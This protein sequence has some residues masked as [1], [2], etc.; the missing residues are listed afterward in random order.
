MVNTTTP[1]PHP[2]GWGRGEVGRLEHWF[3]VGGKKF[4]SESVGVAMQNR[5]FYS[6]VNYGLSCMFQVLR[7][8]GQLTSKVSPYDAFITYIHCM[9]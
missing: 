9:F 5:R 8:L 2:K 1:P 7:S 3:K 6:N 4:C